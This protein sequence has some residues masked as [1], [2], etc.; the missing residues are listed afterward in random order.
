[1]KNMKKDGDKMKSYKDTIWMVTLIYVRNY[2]VNAKK[3]DYQ[4]FGGFDEMN[5]FLSVNRTLI[6]WDILI[7]QYAI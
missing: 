1:M 2:S 6:V 3:T 4:C 7:N 5:K